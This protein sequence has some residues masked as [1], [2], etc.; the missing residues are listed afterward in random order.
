MEIPSIPDKHMARL[1]FVGADYVK[2][3]AEDWYDRAFRSSLGE[4]VRRIPASGKA[5]IEP[6]T[7]LLHSYFAERFPD[8]TP[9]K[10]FL[11][12]VLEDLPSEFCKRMLD[13]GLV[14]D[15]AQEQVID[16]HAIRVKPI[17]E[18][19]DEEL[20][21]VLAWFSKLNPVE[22]AQAK[23][24]ITEASLDELRKILAVDDEFRAKLMSLFAAEVRP[25]IL[26]AVRKFIKEQ[27]LELSDVIRQM[28]AMIATQ[29]KRLREKRLGKEGR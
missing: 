9:T 7:Y 6:L 20:A 14:E 1:A 4:R 23:R 16:V 18:L 13:D 26:S 21:D 17:F 22:Q 25:S 8:D 27:S 10:K 19:S 2:R 24:F 12:S 11:S 3:F 5:V 15:H 29:R 28:N